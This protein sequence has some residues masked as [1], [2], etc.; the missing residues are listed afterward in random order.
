MINAT[1]ELEIA[2]RAGT[3]YFDC[4]RGIDLRRTE[5]ASMAWITQ[6]F[7]GAALMGYSVLFY[8]RASLDT[9][10]AFSMN[11]GQYAMGAITTIL[12]WFLMARIGRRTLFIFG[13]SCM[14]VLLLIVGGLGVSNS[15]GAGWAVGSLLL[16][17]T[18]IYDSTVGPVTYSVIAEIPSSRLKIKTVVLAGNFYNAAGIINNTLMPRMIGLNNWN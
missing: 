14:C 5:I 16:V 17:Y 13:L 2:M 15:R 12:S 9:S 1:N 11:I 18:F 10:N 8:E 4:F 3:G 7:C 6:V